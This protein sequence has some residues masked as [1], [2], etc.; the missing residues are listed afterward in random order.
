LKNWHDRKGM[1]QPNLVGFD[2][3]RSLEAERMF[4]RKGWSR[5]LAGT[6]FQHN[7]GN[8]RS[9]LPVAEEWFFKK[10]PFRFCGWGVA[11]L[12]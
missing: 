3:L 10:L 9:G 6:N 7:I 8:V 2:R 11:A 4:G 12:A 5:T 1:L